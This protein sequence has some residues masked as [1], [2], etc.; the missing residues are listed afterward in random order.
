MRYSIPTNEIQCT[1][2]LIRHLAILKPNPLPQA[3]DLLVSLCFSPFNKVLYTPDTDRK[4][5]LYLLN[6]LK[7]LSQREEEKACAPSILGVL[8]PCD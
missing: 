7:L 5:E 3:T 2:I 8:S 4:K 1:N 6:P